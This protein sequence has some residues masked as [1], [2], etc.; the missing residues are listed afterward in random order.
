M[1]KS[2]SQLDFEKLSGEI[3]LD[4][5]PVTVDEAALVSNNKKILGIKIH[6]GRNRVV[7][8]MFVHLGYEV[9]K[10]DRVV[11]AGLTKKDLPR[12][13]WRHLLKHE[14]LNLKHLK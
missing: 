14:V 7:R 5:G 1:S 12:G 13:K 9:V 4:D 6:V 2:I 8:R 3:H 10:L 11:F